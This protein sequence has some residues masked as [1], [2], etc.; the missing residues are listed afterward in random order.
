MAENRAFA[1]KFSFPYPLLSDE[2]RA[3]GMAYGA[4]DSATA[5]NAKRVAYLVGPDQKIRRVW[6]KA[7]PGTF[8]EEVL[9]S[10]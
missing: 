2:S 9:A 3:V 6:P 10:V 1:E 8:T 5:S 4:A 7:N